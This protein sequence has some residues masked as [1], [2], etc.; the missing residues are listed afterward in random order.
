MAVLCEGD[1]KQKA[2]SRR[3]EKE[4]E[5]MEEEIESEDEEGVREERLSSSSSLKQGKM[6]RMYRDWGAHLREFRAVLV[7]QQ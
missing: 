4:F 7:L 1:E 5:S 3:V 2:M 6:S